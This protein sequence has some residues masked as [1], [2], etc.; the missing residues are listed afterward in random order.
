MN[1]LIAGNGPAAISAIEEIRE[2][3]DE[4]SITL[5][6]KE[7]ERAYSPCYL[8]HYVSGDITRDKLYIKEDDFYEKNNVNTLFGIS[9][10]KVIPERQSVK[11]SDGNTLPYDRLLIAVGAEP[12]LPEIPGIHGD[13][14]FFFKSLEDAE[15]I[16][17]IISKIKKAA[18]IGG[19]FI[20]LEIAEA[21]RKKGISVI[22]IEKETRI[23][24]R[25]LDEEMAGIVKSYLLKN[26]IEIITGK[27][28]E[29]IE[30]KEDGSIKG[31]RTM[32]GI[33]VS[34]D[35]VIVSA[36]VRP[37][38][39]LVEGTGIRTEKGIIVN[40]RMETSIPGIY[41]AGDVAEIEIRGIRKLNPIWLNA[42]VGG[43]IAGANMIGISKKLDTHIPDMNL[44]NLAGFYIFSGGSPVGTGSIK[45]QD[46]SGIKKF[47]F[48]EDNRVKGIQIIGNE[49]LK[50]GLYLN[51]LG[52]SL[53]ETQEIIREFNYGLLLEPSV[54]GL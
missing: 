16:M 37:N 35:I 45:R 26:G 32:D 4:S 48:D 34:A 15:R 28:I 27:V 6:S 24:P 52:R 51:L 54:K 50:G 31:I 17:S 29:E 2:I 25:M 11:L 43:S 18:V 46:S 47:I 5:V 1:I 53:K 10:E 23:L 39:K 40:E 19:G 38:M 8:Y 41:A 36:G 44:I 49:A 12:M 14:V 42:T 22:V 3:D 20:G 7:K 9:I 21:F 33:K 13:G 30:R